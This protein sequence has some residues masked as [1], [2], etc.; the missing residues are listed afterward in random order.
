[1]KKE[2]WL[3]GDFESIVQP[4]EN[5]GVKQ[6]G[7]ELAKEEHWEVEPSLFYR[8]SQ[9]SVLRTFLFIFTIMVLS[10][11]FLAAWEV[12]LFGYG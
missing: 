11:P 7:R 12:C 5:Q 4:E 2:S 6:S 3:Q 1:M 8:S 9:V 10:S